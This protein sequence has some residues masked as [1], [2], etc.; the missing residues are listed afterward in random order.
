MQDAYTGLAELFF[1]T[2][3]ANRYSTQK[4]HS[5][6]ELVIIVYG[7]R[8]AQNRAGDHRKKI[9]D[10]SDVLHGT[11]TTMKFP[12]TSQ[13]NIE[14]INRTPHSQLTEEKQPVQTDIVAQCLWSMEI[15]RS[16]RCHFG[17]T[18]HIPIFQQ[19][20]IVSLKKSTPSA[21]HIHYYT[22]VCAAEGS[23]YLF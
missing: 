1:R 12:W 11:S 20:R 10:G 16:K 22:T 17:R 13:E 6:K 8:A 23:L 14:A 2:K 19:S 7:E 15:I 5:T 4:R 21:T 18:S 9:V 3:A